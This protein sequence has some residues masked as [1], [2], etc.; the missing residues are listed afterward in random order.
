VTEAKRRIRRAGAFR[1]GMAVLLVFA[2]L[3]PVAVFAASPAP[4]G[5]DDPGAS[6]SASADASASAAASTEASAST[7]PSAS[8]AASAPAAPLAP[9]S[10][11]KPD[12]T[13]TDGSKGQR[14]GSGFG[15]ITITGIAGSKLSLETTDGWTR[16]IVVT[17]DTKVTKGGKAATV[18]DLD[19]GDKITFR[20]KRNDDGTYT[21]TSINVPTPKAA[22]KV[23]AVGSTTLTLTAGRGDKTRVIT[24]NSSTVYTFGKDAATKSDVVVGSHVVALGT[25]SGDT[26]TATAVR[27]QPSVVGGEVTAKTSTSLTLK[28]RDGKSVTVHLDSSTKVFVRGK[29]DATVADLAVGDK[30]LASGAL[31]ADGSV[32]ADMVGGGKFGRDGHSGDKSAPSASPTT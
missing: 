7:E 18:S 23:T 4:S 10:T 25:V 19:L 28:T 2:I 22:G 3:V 5:S 24:V 13:K 17:A 11:T 20:Q 1:L 27:I 14:G 15:G 29:K 21:I 9:Q 16:T 12:T 26:F 8:A 6:A 30:V 32:D 31:N